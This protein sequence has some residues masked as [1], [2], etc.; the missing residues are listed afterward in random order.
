MNTQPDFLVRSADG[1][2]RAYDPRGTHLPMPAAVA[3]AWATEPGVQVIAMR[4]EPAQVDGYRAA[5]A[6]RKAAQQGSDGWQ[7]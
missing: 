7:A 3:E 1:A 5:E 4:P 2:L 6:A